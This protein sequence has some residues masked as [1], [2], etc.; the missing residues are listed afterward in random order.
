MAK[1][2]NIKISGMTCANCSLSVSNA[3]KKQG[4]ANISVDFISGEANFEHNE[5]NP[6]NFIKAIENTGYK[7]L[8]SSSEETTDE[9]SNHYTKSLIISTLASIPL[10]LAMFF[11]YNGYFQLILCLVVVILATK[12]FGKTGLGSI[13]NGVAN[14]DVMVLLG[15]Y[16]A[17]FL[18]LY[19]LI[20]GNP[21]LYFETGAVIVTLVLFGKY[22]EKNSLAKTQ[23]AIKAFSKLLPQKAFKIKNLNEKEGTNIDVKDIKPGDFLW[24][25]DGEKIPADGAII[26]GEGLLDE[27]LLTGENETI[28]KGKG[29]KVITG[30]INTEGNFVMVANKVG[31]NTYLSSIIELAKKARTQKPEIQLMADKISAIFVPIVVVISVITL[32]VWHFMGAPFEVA[33]INAISVLVIS[34]PCAM[35]L[36]TPT[37]IAVALGTGAKSGIF[38]KSSKGLEALHKAKYF[39]FD[40]TG[41]I[42]QTELTVE[43]LITYRNENEQE[44][45]NVIYGIEQSSLHPIAKAL[46]SHYKSSKKLKPFI[47]T[48][49]IK[50]FGVVGDDLEGN[51]Y[52]IGNLQTEFNGIAVEK[53]N[54]IIGEIIMSSMIRNNAK[55]VISSLEFQ[56]IETVLI[57]GD[58]IENSQKVADEVGIKKVFASQKPEE[59]IKLVDEYNQKGL[60]IFIGDGINDGPALTKASL[61]ISLAKATDVAINSAD[62]IIEEKQLFTNLDKALKLSSNSFSIIKQNLFWAFFYNAMAIPL[63]ALGYLNPMI[64]AGAMSLSS[65]F[66]I[67]N[68]LRLRKSIK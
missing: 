59:K 11:P 65:L 45:I 34:C 15:C 29:Q 39:L 3:I 48:K 2:E 58:N 38:F 25:K 4:G 7:V 37:A 14:M 53:N 5:S 49:E 9:Q 43:N 19:H 62:I 46:L 21:S 36:A 54:V 12:H 17:F 40:K 64:A 66:V 51:H 47:N 52:K 55:K 41:T 16:S 18:S 33:A 61:G 60:T 44:I 26:E 20:I 63:A 35:G 67:T 24:V 56:N 10:L 23:D 31:V 28:L 57:S 42:T 1:T 8:E 32:V 27:A 30:S 6:I 50:G 22:V 13:K 68:S